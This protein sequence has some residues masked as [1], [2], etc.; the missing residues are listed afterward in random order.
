MPAGAPSRLCGEASRGRKKLRVEGQPVEWKPCSVVPES[1][2][3]ERAG[4]GGPDNGG[5]SAAQHAKD[6]A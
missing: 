6:G 4:E 1:S 5:E 3:V 2:I